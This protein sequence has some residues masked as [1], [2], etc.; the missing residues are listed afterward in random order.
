MNRVI[1]LAVAAAV[2]GLTAAPIAPA[3]HAEAGCS[4]ARTLPG[5]KAPMR[6]L[7]GLLSVNPPPSE[8][9][10]KARLTDGRTGKPRLTDGRTGSTWGADGRTDATQVTGGVPSVSRAVTPTTRRPPAGSTSGAIA[11]TWFAST[12]P[13]ASAPSA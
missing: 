10:G 6:G 13:C 8:R 1:K 4:T 5:G 12:A 2:F 3:A 9:T 11:S 7:S